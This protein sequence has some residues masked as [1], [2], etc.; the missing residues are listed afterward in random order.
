MKTFGS[1]LRALTGVERRLLDA[2]L[3]HVT[4]RQGKSPL[5]WRPAVRCTFFF[6]A[7][8]M[9][10]AHHRDGTRFKRMKS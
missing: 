8:S 3:I 7:T 10:N 9:S 1:K 4:P 5:S 2:V 6:A